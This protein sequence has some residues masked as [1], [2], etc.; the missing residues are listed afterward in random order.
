[1]QAGLAYGQAGFVLPAHLKVAEAAVPSNDPA[2]RGTAPAAPHAGLQRVALFALLSALVWAPVPLGSNRIWSLSLL[3]LWVWGGIALALMAHAPRLATGGWPRPVR[4]AAPGL[5]LALACAGWVALQLS[6]HPVW[7]NLWYTHDAHATQL[8]LLRTLTYAGAMLLC[9]LAL[10]GRAQVLWVLAALLLGGLLQAL[11][12]AGLYAAGKP[13]VYWFA[14]I[15]PRSRASGTFVN[16]DHLAGYLEIT[17]AAGMGLMLALLAPSTRSR[18]WA[19]RMVA[20]SAFVMSPKMLVRLALVMLVMALVL[21]RSRAGNGAF[22]IGI[23]G[24]AVV[25]ALRSV[26]W[27]RPAL[28]LVASML[29]VDLV[30]IGQWVGLDTV[31]KRMQGTAEAT[32]LRVAEFGLAGSPPKPGEESLTQRM[33][34]PMSSLPLV[35][36]KPVAGWGG[37]GYQLAYPPIKP[38]TIFKGFWSH[39]HNDYVQVAVDLGVVGLALWVSVGVFSVWRLWPLLGDGAERT[40]RGVAVAAL[41]ALCCLGLHSVVDFNLHIPAIAMSLSVLLALLWALPG[42]PSSGKRRRKSAGTHK[43]KPRE[44]DE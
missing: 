2:A 20:A 1:M 17:L 22:F 12:S 16:P 10:A 28:W 31:V 33:A 4:A 40:D 34:V 6:L 23:V 42:L 13:F 39:A 24:V 11:L 29:I 3:A 41:M 25:V 27:R 9:A 38:S 8:Y 7:P 37:G 18:S 26:E 36:Q 44:E 35:Q 15:D 43:S 5:L 32:S 21:T 30:I 14:L 19:E